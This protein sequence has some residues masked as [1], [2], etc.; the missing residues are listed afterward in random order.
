ML[1]ATL[2]LDEV[3]ARLARLAVEVSGVSQGAIYEYCPETDTLVYKAEWLAESA[4]REAA[5]Q[6][7]GAVYQMSECPNER[8]ALAGASAVEECLSDPG[9]DAVRRQVMEQ[10]GEATSLTLPLR[11][12]ESPAGLLRLYELERERRFEP[13]ELDLLEALGEIAGAAIL[14]ARLFRKEREQ[15]GRLLELFESTTGLAST[16]ELGTIVTEIEGGAARLFGDARRVDTWLYGDDGALAPAG[17][18]VV[19][20]GAEAGTTPPVSPPLPGALAV[21]ALAALTPAQVAGEDASELVVPFAVRGQAV[22]LVVVHTEGRRVFADTEVEA[23]QVLANQAAVAVDNA[24]LYRYV[25]RQA[26]RDGL[27]G[28]FNHRY[29]QERLLQE[30]ALA[31][32][33]DL[34][35]S[36]LMIDVDDFKKFN[37]EFGHQ[38]GDEVVREIGGILAGPYRHGIDLPARYGGEEFAIILPHTRADG[39]PSEGQAP[40]DG[41]EPL[42]PA[43]CGALVV[44]ERLRRAVAERAFAGTGGAATRT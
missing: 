7:V 8:A 37:D 15:S 19:A 11:S 40:K 44:A 33:Y 36:L 23:L 43:G 10:F 42:P 31:H 26:I 16:F 41:E 34:P 21:Q 29:F 30:C 39:E 1:A 4:P 3:L 22:G 38:L 5:Q 18:V 2:D 20:A 27:T 9:L 24:R 14:N 25:E 13:A 28:L 12:G 32:R 6:E 35:L 17:D